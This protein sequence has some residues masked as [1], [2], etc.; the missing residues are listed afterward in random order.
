MCCLPQVLI[1]SHIFNTT[2]R[3]DGGAILV[4]D[5]ALLVAEGC[6]ISQTTAGAEAGAIVVA[7][8]S[9]FAFVTDCAITWAMASNDGGA[10]DV[11]AGTL[12]LLRSIIAH[13]SW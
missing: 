10:C 4:F 2:S 7:A 9:S 6:T 5:D 11:K 3:D 13:T 12:T 1:D 8:I